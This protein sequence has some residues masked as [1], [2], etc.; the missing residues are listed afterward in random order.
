VIGAV[1]L[2][3]GGSERL[4]QPKQLLR[5]GERTLVRHVVEVVLRSR[6][7]PVWVVLG[8]SADRI[9]PELDELDVRVVD[10]PRWRDGMSSSIRAGIEAVRESGIEVEAVI[11][12]PCDQ[13]LL[14]TEVLEGLCEARRLERKPMAACEYAGTVGIP[15]LFEAAMFAKLAALVGG[16]GAKAL[17]LE[18]PDRVAR[19][20]WREGARDVDLPEDSCGLRGEPI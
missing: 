16:G 7:R 17:L 11:L 5:V 14:R 20:V 8:A 13:P 3:A 10:N 1:V 2:A 9:R 12:V 18:D 19:V 4:G 15:A 6:C